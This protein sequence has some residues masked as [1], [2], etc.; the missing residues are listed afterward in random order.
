LSQGDAIYWRAR[1]AGTGLRR[2][3]LSLAGNHTGVILDSSA[4]IIGGTRFLFKARRRDAPEKIAPDCRLI[5]ARWRPFP[6][7][8][9]LGTASGA[10]RPGSHYILWW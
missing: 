1:Y 6:P 3:A 4:R 8:T 10:S 2:P 9:R 5:P 7:W